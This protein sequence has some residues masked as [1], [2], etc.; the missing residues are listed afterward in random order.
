MMYI[1]T[2]KL[3]KN[4]PEGVEISNDEIAFTAEMT[5]QIMNIAANNNCIILGGD[6]LTL[7]KKFTYDNW[8]YQPETSVSL[9]ENVNRSIKKAKEY[10][11]DYTK[12]NGSDFLYSFVISDSYMEVKNMEV[13]IE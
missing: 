2:A 11:S 3:L 8:Y 7:D 6:V 9:S 1:S 13:P 12:K 4:L 10:I 5:L